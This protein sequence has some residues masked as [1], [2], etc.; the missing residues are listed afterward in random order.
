MSDVFS[1]DEL[2]TRLAGAGVRFVVIGGFAVIAHGVVRATEDLDI[3]PDPEYENLVRLAR[4]LREL[5]ARQIGVDAHL[6]P[7]QP[8]DPDGLAEGGSFQLETRFGRLYVLQESDQVPAYGELASSAL[9]ID[10]FRGIEL[11]VCSLEQLR[12]MKRAA[13]RPKDLRDLEDLEIAHGG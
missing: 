10:E 3:V 1:A 13:G 5:D 9:L 6:L 2:L 11:A 12:R 8:T 4:V 7:N